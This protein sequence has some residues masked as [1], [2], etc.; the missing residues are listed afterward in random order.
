MHICSI[1]TLAYC[2]G[3]QTRYCCF[4]NKWVYKAL[5][6]TLILLSDPKVWYT[7]VSEKEQRRKWYQSQM[8]QINI[9]LA[10]NETRRL[11]W[12][13][14]TIAESYGVFSIS[15]PYARKR[16]IFLKKS[17]GMRTWIQRYWNY[18]FSCAN[19][20]RTSRLTSL[21][22]SVNFSSLS[23]FPYSTFKTRNSGARFR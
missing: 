7:N 10:I 8:S 6:N 11:V 23:L 17:L 13:F 12:R 18:L 9:A 15:L 3:R 4:Y 21:P 22:A 1:H 16:T 19:R 20:I 14:P 5:L 2:P